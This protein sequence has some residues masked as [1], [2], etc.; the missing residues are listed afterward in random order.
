M[1]KVRIFYALQ[2]LSKDLY[3]FEK[4]YPITAFP[5]KIQR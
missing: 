5:T 3:I 4:F 1:A 2:G